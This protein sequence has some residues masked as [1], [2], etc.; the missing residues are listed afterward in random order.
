MVLDVNEFIWHFINS[1]REIF[2][3]V[4]SGKLVTTEFD[5]SGDLMYLC[6]LHNKSFTQENS[7][8]CLKRYYKHD[9]L[10]LF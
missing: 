5:V 9:T 6:G 2:L 10:N 8:Y 1:C 3:L 4:L 7:G